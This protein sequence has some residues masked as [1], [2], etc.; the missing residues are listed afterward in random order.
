MKF[1]SKFN[2]EVAEATASDVAFIKTFKDGDNTVRFLEEI[3]TEWTM[4]YEHFSEGVTRSYPCLGD[5]CP[6]CVATSERERR[7]TKRYLANAIDGDY[8]N[9]FKIPQSMIASL[10]KYSDKYKTIVDRDYTISRSGSGLNT[11][12]LA[13]PEDRQPIDV[14]AYRSEFKDH[15]ILLEA[16]FKDRW[17]ISPD[18]MVEGMNEDGEEFVIKAEITAARRSESSSGSKKPTLKKLSKDNKEPI[19]KNRLDDSGEPPWAKKAEEKEDDEIEESE[20]RAM[21]HKKLAVYFEKAELEVPDDF[22]DYSI[23][24]LVDYLIENS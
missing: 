10:L 6:G 20:L 21:N 2:R 7:K 17:G 23:D 3:E 14:D 22:E 11:E 19:K 5:V 1:G 18:E 24:D 8:V 9:L 13:I 4:Y 16:A 15:Q 12:Y